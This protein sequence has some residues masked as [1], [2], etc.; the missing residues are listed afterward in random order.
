MPARIAGA[1]VQRPATPGAVID[2]DSRKPD[3]CIAA[4][5]GTQWSGILP[6]GLDV[7]K[8]TP[9]YVTDSCECI[10]PSGERN[11]PKT[12]VIWGG[13]S[14]TG[15]RSDCYG[16]GNRPRRPS[17]GGEGRGGRRFVRDLTTLRRLV[18]DGPADAPERIERICR[19]YPDAGPPPPGEPWSP[20]Y[21]LR[22]LTLHLLE[23][24]N[25]IGTDTQRTS[26][27]A[28]RMIGL[29]LKMRS[30]TMR[31]F[32]QPDNIL[33]FVHL[34]AHLR[35]AGTPPQRKTAC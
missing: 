20:K 1:H 22:M 16:G 24:W 31:G 9:A 5:G 17:H 6:A 2:S 12:C 10:I 34:M 23:T 11:R 21:R 30:A 18:R 7:C 33:R 3:R 27:S 32:V 19:R 4:R 8:R 35:E 28:E 26:N 29:L 15:T 13:G 14:K 25:R